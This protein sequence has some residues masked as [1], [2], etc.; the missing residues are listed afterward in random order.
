MR[1]QFSRREIENFNPNRAPIA[2]AYR[3]AG[4]RWA[5]DERAPDYDSD[6]AAYWAWQRSRVVGIDL[7]D[8]ELTAEARAIASHAVLVTVL[9]EHLEAPETARRRPAAW[10]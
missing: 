3:R 6:P 9:R 7:E 2:L 4:A 10:A 1:T 8:R 5:T